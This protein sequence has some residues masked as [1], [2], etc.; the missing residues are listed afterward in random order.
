MR[1]KG[2]VINTL[3]IAFKKLNYGSNCITQENGIKYDF[4]N[5]QPCALLVFPILNK[6]EFDV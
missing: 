6:V 3:N 4:G 1:A 5:I 2:Y